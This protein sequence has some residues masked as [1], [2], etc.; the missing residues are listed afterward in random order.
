MNKNLEETRNDK[1]NE[2]NYN[3]FTFFVSAFVNR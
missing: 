2:N 3:V 1:K